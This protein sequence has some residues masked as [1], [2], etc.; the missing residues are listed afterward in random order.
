M[1]LRGISGWFLFLLRMDDIRSSME[2]DSGAGNA[3]AGSAGFEGSDERP[4]KRAAGAMAAP[5]SSALGMSGHMFA[6]HSAAS[7]ATSAAGIASHL[8]APSEASDEE[9]EHDFHIVAD[10][11]DHAEHDEHALQHHHLQEPPAP[12]A[13]PAPAP[14][15]TAWPAVPEPSTADALTLLAAFGFPTG[16]GDGSASAAGDTQGHGGDA[17]VVPVPGP[18]AAAATSASTP[19][20]AATPEIIDLDHD[21][22]ESAPS[23]PA[24]ASSAV[25]QEGSTAAAE[26]QPP[27]P[28]Q[29]QQLPDLDPPPPVDSCDELDE[30]YAPLDEASVN[31][32]RAIFASP[33]DTAVYDASHIMEREGAYHAWARIKGDQVMM[34]ATAAAVNPADAAAQAASSADSSAPVAA[35][36]HHKHIVRISDNEYKVLFPIPAFGRVA[37]TKPGKPRGK[38]KH[39]VYV[40]LG[41][42]ATHRQAVVAHDLCIRVAGV[43]EKRSINETGS[44]VAA[45]LDAAV[46]AGWEKIASD[47]R[48]PDTGAAGGS[49]SSSA[50]SGGAAQ[51]AGGRKSRKKRKRKSSR[52]TWVYLGPDGLPIAPVETGGEDEDDEEDEDEEGSDSE[53]EEATSGAEAAAGAGG[54][55]VS[56]GTAADA[57]DAQKQ[58]IKNQ[59]DRRIDSLQW[60]LSDKGIFRG[61]IR[62]NASRLV[63]NPERKAWLNGSITKVTLPIASASTAAAAAP[64][65]A[66]V[67]SA[68][69]VQ[70]TVKKPGGGTQSLKAWFDNYSEAAVGKELASSVLRLMDLGFE[71]SRNDDGPKLTSSVVLTIQSYALSLL[72]ELEQYDPPSKPP[73]PT[74]RRQTADSSSSS[75]ATAAAAAAATA[76]APSS[77]V[78]PLTAA[79]HA[80]KLDALRRLFKPSALYHTW[81]LAHAAD[82]ASHVDATKQY[83][84]ILPEPSRSARNDASNAVGAGDADMATDEPASSPAALEADLVPGASSS[85]A[86][87]SAATGGVAAPEYRVKM[88]HSSADGRDTSNFGAYSLKAEAVLAREVVVLAMQRLA[89]G[90]RSIELPVAHE[91]INKLLDETLEKSIAVESEAS[92][93]ESQPIDDLK[94]LMREGA[95]H[96]WACS[97]V[98]AYSS[99]IDDE[100]TYVNVRPDVRAAAGGGGGGS[101][102]GTAASAVGDGRPSLGGGDEDIAAKQRRG[103]GRPPKASP[104]AGAASSRAATASSSAS[105]TD[106]GGDAVDTGAAADGAAAPSSSSALPSAITGYRIVIAIGP[107]RSNHMFGVFSSKAAAVIGREI[108]VM[109]LKRLGVADRSFELP[110]AHDEIN[111]LLAQHLPEYFDTDITMGTAAAPSSAMESEAAA[112]PALVVPAKR[113]RARPSGASSRAAASSSAAA[114][115]STSLDQEYVSS[116]SS[117]STS[118]AVAAGSQARCTPDA[119]RRLFYFEGPYHKWVGENASAFAAF[120]DEDKVYPHISVKVKRNGQWL[121]AQSAAGSS[122]I[123]GGGADHDGSP[124][125][126]PLEDQDDGAMQQFDASSSSG[127]AGPRC[128]YRVQLAINRAHGNTSHVCGTYYRKPAAVLG[129]ELAVVAARR[130]NMCEKSFEL[131]EAHD[132]I[133]RLLN[134]TLEGMLPSDASAAAAVSA[135]EPHLL[136]SGEMLVQLQQASS[137]SP[138]AAHAGGSNDRP[139]ATTHGA[140]AEDDQQ[141]YDAPASSTPVAA[142]PHLPSARSSPSPS[143]RSGPA[144]AS[145][146]RKPAPVAAE[147]EVLKRLFRSDGAYNKWVM[148]NAPLF[149]HYIGRDEKFP[150]V[151]EIQ[152]GGASLSSSSSAARAA[153]AAGGGGGGGGATDDWGVDTS[154]SSGS[155]VSAATAGVAYQVLYNQTKNGALHNFYFCTF[156]SK[157]AGVLARELSVMA[158][159]RLGVADKPSLLPVA[160]DAINKLLDETLDKYIAEGLRTME[161]EQ[162]TGAVVSSS[163][164]MSTE[165]PLQEVKPSLQS[166]LSAG[167]G[168]DGGEPSEAL[169]HQPAPVTSPTSG[170]SG[171]K[172]AAPRFDFRKPIG[173][174]PSPR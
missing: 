55:T 105:A 56:G 143:P 12:P 135:P 45:Q 92:S 100:K 81:V 173:S 136:Q 82:F 51:P 34:E 117:P 137:L 29:Q 79:Q 153:S 101:T 162:A 8:V 174:K 159:K 151:H 36:F 86:A 16:G 25:K 106:V 138:P 53:G 18:P 123:G 128:M 77:T 109:A 167:I 91:A 3:W 5:L 84:N 90:D 35:S 113:P 122:G 119:F 39:T 87:A 73:Q 33:V 171:K 42:F 157:T 139:R 150:G 158:L 129:R 85:A 124:S 148:E 75:S 60:W 24:D 41:V 10:H 69:Q 54:S 103:P 152:R 121:S 72:K 147:V 37:S 27:P 146:S 145:R 96:D 52:R 65:S 172:R 88:Y 1:F 104:G 163:S 46:A 144:S 160:H 164:D 127:A 70:L 19:S 71:A 140:G 64:S 50:S 13:A 38:V 43:D 166:S 107:E 68:Y 76:P 108:V 2:F 57:V 14:L 111:H 7:R 22:K 114:A 31:G 9:D 132:A 93:K 62:S 21:V 61:W 141:M 168:D 142:A 23:V 169:H 115:A 154:S 32:L 118:A 149:A 165:L 83:S 11:E 95:F 134:E 116:S 112:A 94:R 131:P 40:S 26:T 120:V 97:S 47:L 126:A 49:A 6:P 161:A 48:N 99:Y 28:P 133:N 125:P 130:L 155:G 4:R 59:R 110:A 170:P 78:N 30:D 102:G 156:S 17:V 44:A 63:P 98:D 20:I 80:L 58:R 67:A 15:P 89:L 74:F 66:A